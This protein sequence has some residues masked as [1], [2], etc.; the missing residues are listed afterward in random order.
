MSL[1]LYNTDSTTTTCYTTQFFFRKLSQQTLSFPQRLDNQTDDT[2]IVYDDK[3]AEG[4]DKSNDGRT[5]RNFQ[6]RWLSFDGN[7]MFF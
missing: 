7:L 2:L 3:P 1:H 5:C 6:N 4:N